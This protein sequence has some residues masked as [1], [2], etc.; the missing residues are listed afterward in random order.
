MAEHDDETPDMMDRLNETNR[1]L[2]EARMLP[3]GKKLTEDQIA[4]V[5][6]RFNAYLAERGL[7]PAQVAREVDYV[8]SVISSYQSGTY[9]G[10]NT[11]ITHAVNDWMERDARREAARRPQDY[12][13]TWVAET[14]RT[15]A[16]QADKQGVMAAIVA[17]A[18]CGKSKVLKTLV[19]EMRG[20][21]VYC[22]PD[23]TERELL[24]KIAVAL[25]FKREIGTKIAMRQYIIHSLAGTKR[26]IFLD[27]AQQLRR[28]IRVVRS[29]YDQ[30]EVPIIM[31]GT[32][33][34]LQYIDDRAD[35]RGQFSS[36]CI[37][38]SVIESVHNAENPTGG[39]QGRD[40]FTIEEIKKF[41]AS[42]KIRLTTDGL[43]LAWLLACQVNH[44]TLRLVEK[45]AGIAADLN[46][47]SMAINAEHLMEALELFRGIN[48]AAYMEKLVG[49][50]EDLFGASAV[51]AAG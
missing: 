27:E 13:S 24:Y 33:E 4:A 15:I 51:A 16:Y 7:K 18:G 42:K 21:Y 50:Y 19:D 17:P 48:E 6:E 22:D 35:G 12:V 9:K 39:R 41:F 37:R 30:A 44:G 40:L 32:A 2:L 28:S 25:G 34:I 31:A 23:L 11:R 46:R 43:R 26:V 1:I 36:R 5:R 38:Y 49:K 45:L 29:I 47:E 20:V 8:P 10:D 14:M 3:R